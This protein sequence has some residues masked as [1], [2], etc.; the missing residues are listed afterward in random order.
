M[1]EIHLGILLVTVVGILWADHLGFQYFRGQR[2]TLPA[3][4][5]TRLHYA[6]SLGLL[7]MLVTGTAMAYDRFGYLS[8]Q[9]VFWLKMF[10]VAVLVGNALFITRLMQKAFTTPFL[11][12]S[13]RERT[14]LLVSGAASAAGWIGAA[15]IG[16]FFL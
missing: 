7:G 10:F 5:V 6:V 14:V 12:L 1:E 13:A 2:T 11:E 4:L 3:L 9:P 8:S 15:T 16:L